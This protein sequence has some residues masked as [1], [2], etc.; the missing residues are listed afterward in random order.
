M[1]ALADASV[2]LTDF[3]LSHT[4]VEDSIEVYVDGTQRNNGWSFDATNNS[5]VFSANIPEEGESV[6]I[7]Y[8]AAANCD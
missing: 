3:E 4:A 5:V 1:E 8:A 7:D 6:Q 2:Q